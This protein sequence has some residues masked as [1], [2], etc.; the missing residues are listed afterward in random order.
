MNTVL[1]VVAGYPSFVLNF[2][3]VRGFESWYTPG[4]LST[5]LVLLM[6]LSISV[7]LVIGVINRP[8]PER[9]PE[10]DPRAPTRPSPGPTRRF[11]QGVIR[12][13]LLLS[14]GPLILHA[15]M[16]LYTNL[17][18]PVELGSVTETVNASLAYG[19]VYIPLYAGAA[20]LRYRLA[21]QRREA[22]TTP[23]FGKQMRVL[24]GLFELTF[25]IYFLISLSQV[26]GVPFHIMMRPALVSAI[27]TIVAV[28][29]V[30]AVV[31]LV[32]RGNPPVKG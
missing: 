14:G 19:A 4:L 23:R 3:L 30:V 8:P 31:L 21:R 15:L 26:H 1:D 20:R 12:V 28:T 10:I 11:I 7:A 27:G 24:A 18:G 6:L 16:R 13:S 9:Q 25:P 17:V 22:E 2:L 5:D 29:G 32:L